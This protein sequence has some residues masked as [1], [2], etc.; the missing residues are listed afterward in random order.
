MELTQLEY[1]YE[2]AK[3]QH[4]T[5]TANALNIS[6]PALSK[7]INRLENDLN[8]KLFERD[9]KNIRLSDAGVIA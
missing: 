3:R 6:Q 8:V 7:A 4:I 2:T 5:Q 9:G 1:F